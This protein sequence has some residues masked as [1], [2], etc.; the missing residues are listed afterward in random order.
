MS[1]RLE[2]HGHFE[3][4]AKE[5]SQL[6]DHLHLVLPFEVHQ[7]VLHGLDLVK[8][9]S[10]IVKQDTQGGQ[11][12]FDTFTGELEISGHQFQLSHMVVGSGLLAADGHV[13]VSPQK[14]LD[15][16][17]N[18]ELKKSVSLVAIPMTVTGTLEHPVV[19]PS[20]SALAG[21]AVGTAVLGP[22]VGTSL[23]INASKGLDKLKGL[24]GGN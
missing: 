5:A 21:A 14:K 8:A 12:E 20:K 19:Y 1:G 11:T 18:V 22:G 2:G 4:Q 10:L 13:T 24:F 23:G 16:L 9:A 3:S 17:I 15:G 7:G 6:V